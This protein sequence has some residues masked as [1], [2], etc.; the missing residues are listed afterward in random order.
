MTDWH[1]I[2]SN[3]AIDRLSIAD[4]TPQQ[5]LDELARLGNNYQ[6][7]APRLAGL[8]AWAVDTASMATNV[9]QW[10]YYPIE[11]PVTKEG[12]GPAILGIDAERMTYE[13]WDKC[14]TTH[15]SFDNL[16]DAINLAMK[17]TMEVD[18]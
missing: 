18:K 1:I 11:M 3:P 5:R 12:F 8:I 16:P 10:A 6:K 15:A 17:L 14:Y 4:M 2:P 13:V 7:V 9:R